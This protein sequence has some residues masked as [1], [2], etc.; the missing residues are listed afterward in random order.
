LNDAEGIAVTDARIAAA[1]ISLAGGDAGA[2]ARNLDGG[3][4]LYPG[5]QVPA[6]HRARA[7][8]MAAQGDFSQALESATAAMQ[9]RPT[10]SRH[11]A[12]RALVGHLSGGTAQAN[13]LLDG[14]AD[15]DTRPAVR[16]V[17]ARILADTGSD[18]VRAV[19]E[20]TAVIE[21]L[22]DTATPYELAWAHLI[23]A[24]QGEPQSAIEEA[25]AAAEHTPP[26]D[27]AFMMELVRVF[28]RNGAASDA[29]QQ[30]GRMADN[31]PVD[32]HE[33]ALLTAEVALALGD[34]GRA[35]TALGD[36][37][38]GSRRDLMQGQ[39][40]EARHATA[41]AVP[42]YRRVMDE[43]DG[44]EGR[45][46][47]VRLARIA[48]AEDDTA[49]VIELLESR[50]PEAVDDL[51]LVP[52]LG[53]AYVRADRLD[54]ASRVIDLALNRRPHAASLL[55]VQG[56]ILLAQSESEAAIAPL[57]AAAEASPR[58]A[59]TRAN[60]GRAHQ[61]QGHATEATTAYEAALE[62]E[63]ANPQALIGLAQLAFE[64]GDFDAT[65][66][67]LTAASSTGQETLAIAR[68][69]A[70]LEVMRGSGADAVS[71]VRTLARQNRD[72]I[73]WTALGDLYTQAEADRGAS[74]AYARALE[75]EPGW[76]EAL[77]G[78]AFLQIR[79]GNSSGASSLLAQVEASAQAAGRS[80]ALLPRIEAARG[81]LAVE[82]H[83]FD[84]AVAHANAALEADGQESS[85]HLLLG[86]V[87]IERG[88]DP[89]EHL[90]NAVAAHAPPPEALGQLVPRLSGEEQCALARRYLAV[91]PDGYDA[92]AVRRVVGRCG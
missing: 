53:R 90:Q 87:A 37:G 6:A 59:L 14:V 39:I 25:R 38:A 67:R 18:P 69:R 22:S 46:A 58:D 86:T 12:L 5:D 8:A 91:C 4:D 36:A 65:D 28:L 27:G 80:P 84:Q 72:A 34:L 66:T 47:A 68:L 40:H 10:A 89:T 92:A 44:P 26:L 42:L 62:I 43:D 85:A 51:E 23:R 11:I 31:L 19:Q 45:A 60:L 74:H 54:D 15:A 73:I 20:A 56:A 52:L 83:D 7:F 75:V 16:V 82:D 71:L 29:D 24:S 50:Q 79:A 21:Q 30:L 17:R 33:R 77:I 63:P 49:E 55:A 13:T 32:R 9:E 78:Q 88:Q 57:T 3:L 2:A 64:A 1:L 70:Q 81:W 61:L 76:P 48:M 41:A 35:E